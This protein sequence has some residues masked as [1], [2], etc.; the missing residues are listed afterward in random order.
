MGTGNNYVPATVV[1]LT[2]CIE[3]KCNTFSADI[4]V[5]VVAKFEI[6]QGV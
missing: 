5:D 1:H 2:S 6:N 3:L 4:F